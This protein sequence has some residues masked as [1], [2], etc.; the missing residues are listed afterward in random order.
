MWIRMIIVTQV[1]VFVLGGC[2]S[3]KFELQSS[4]RRGYRV[5]SIKNRHPQW[6]ELTIQKVAARQVEIGMTR[7]MVWEALGKADKI[8]QQGNEEKWGYEII[9]DRYTHVERELVYAV[10][11]ENGRVMRTEGDRSRLSYTN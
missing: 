9:I 7:E 6:D 11:F 1:V 2:A 8:L 5:E 10:Y 3:K 4:Q